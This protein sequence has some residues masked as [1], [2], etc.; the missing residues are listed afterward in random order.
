MKVIE[1]SYEIL[2]PDPIDQNDILRSIEAAGRTCYKSEDKMSEHSHEELVNKFLSRNH[3]AMIEFGP[4]ITVRFVCNRGFTHE[5][6]RHRLC[7]FAQESTRYCNYSKDK[8]GSEL[9]VVKPPW[10]GAS[11]A[12]LMNPDL[13]FHEDDPLEMWRSA[14]LKCEKSYIALVNAGKSPQEARGVLPIDIK[15]EIVAKANIREWLHIFSLRTTPKAHPSMQQ[16]MNPLQNEL[17]HLLPLIFD[18]KDI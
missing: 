18:R 5:M 15:T 2:D 4:S 13:T 3:L 8:H 17:K 7:S 11:C 14:M 12:Q 1:P 9:T 10:I 16:L 6:V